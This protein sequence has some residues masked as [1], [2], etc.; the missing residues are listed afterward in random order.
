MSRVNA[1]RDERPLTSSLCGERPVFFCVENRGRGKQASVDKEA[2]VAEQRSG[3]DAPLLLDRQAVSGPR[4]PRND[5][6]LAMSIPL[7]VATVLTQHV[8]LELECLDR[9]YLSGYVPGL[10]REGGAAYFFRTHRGQPFASSALMEPRAYCGAGFEAL[11][12]DCPFGPDPIPCSATWPSQRRGRRHMCPC[13]GGFSGCRG[14]VSPAAGFSAQPH[15]PLRS[16][17]PSPDRW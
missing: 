5:R 9:L 16:S 10:Q 17:S 14:R 13:R 3:S 1:C 12:H 11:A 2:P 8:T 4:G 6:S 7:N 15:W